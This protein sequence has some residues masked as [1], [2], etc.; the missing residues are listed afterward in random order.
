MAAIGRMKLMIRVNGET[1]HVEVIYVTEMQGVAQ[2]RHIVSVE[3]ERGPKR[4]TEPGLT[5]E[6]TRIF[7]LLHDTEA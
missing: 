5:K 4:I 2:K 6:A 1:Y 3:H 7:H